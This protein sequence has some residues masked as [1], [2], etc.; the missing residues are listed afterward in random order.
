[1]E[2]EIEEGKQEEQ[3][4]DKENFGAKKGKINE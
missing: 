2:I 3:E 1:M 4:R